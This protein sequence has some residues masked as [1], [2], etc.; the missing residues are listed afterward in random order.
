M[1]KLTP[2]FVFC[3]LALALPA[4]IAS[5]VVS[6][7]FSQS[8]NS[9]I[10]TPRPTVESIIFGSEVLGVF[11]PES[12]STRCECL[13]VWNGVHWNE[14]A[15][16]TTFGR[17]ILDNKGFYRPYNYSSTAY[18]IELN[19][20]DWSKVKL[21]HQFSKT[22]STKRLNDLS[23][24]QL[25][26]PHAPF[27]Y[28]EMNL[29]GKF[30]VFRLETPQDQSP[31]IE[32]WLKKSSFTQGGNDLILSLTYDLYQTGSG[33]EPGTFTAHYQFENGSWHVRP[34]N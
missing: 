24:V 16:Y 27:V 14:D 33:Q 10:Q 22:F 6:T 2:V 9:L 21:S 15:Y 30:K 32:V 8:P 7:R 12:V 26:S 28:V 11:I 18:S 29:N 31:N 3:V 13:L 20:K 4:S 25:D 5:E 1:N 17:H 19:Q 23:V 34:F